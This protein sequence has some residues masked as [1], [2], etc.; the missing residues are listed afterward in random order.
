MGRCGSVA[1]SVQYLHDVAD[2]TA[3]DHVPALS[4]Y[5]LWRV[6]CPNISGIWVETTA[7][8]KLSSK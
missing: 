6:L 4:L 8:V 5:R 2:T 1:K 3:D 7:E